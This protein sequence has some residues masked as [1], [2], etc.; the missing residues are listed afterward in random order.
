[1]FK[2][3]KQ[4]QPNADY[5]WLAYYYIPSE[6][7]K[8]SSL[9]CRWKFIWYMLRTKRR[10]QIQTVI[11]TSRQT[12]SRM[13]KIRYKREKAIMYQVNIKRRWKDDDYMRSRS[14]HYPLPPPLHSPHF[15]CPS[16]WPLYWSPLWLRQAQL[17]LAAILLFYSRNPIEVKSSEKLAFCQPLFFCTS[18]AQTKEN[19]TQ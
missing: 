8:I 2:Q 12:A 7:I 16:L 11:H 10:R 9:S 17:H 1:M 15:R 4:F 5:K 3:Q 14:S 13:T 18:A 6:K 19:K